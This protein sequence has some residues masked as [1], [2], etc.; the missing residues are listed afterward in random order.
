M[1]QN[2]DPAYA[3]ALV[4]II[5]FLAVFTFAKAVREYRDDAGVVRETAQSVTRPTVLP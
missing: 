5:F 4:A 1:K 2:H 3:D